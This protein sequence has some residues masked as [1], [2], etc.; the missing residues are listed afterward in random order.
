MLPE[1]QKRGIGALLTQPGVEVAEQMSVPVYLEATDRAVRLYEKLGFEKLEQGV[2]LSADIVGSGEPAEAPVMVKMPS[3]GLT[4][5]A[6]I[7]Q[8][9]A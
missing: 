1:F 3:G 8:V 6:W 7:K 4:F 5:D 9:R 2:A